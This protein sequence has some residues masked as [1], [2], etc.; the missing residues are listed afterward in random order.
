L[1]KLKGSPK[2][3]ATFST[4]STHFRHWASPGSIGTVRSLAK[5]SIRKYLI[6]HNSWQDNYIN[7]F[8][9]LNASSEITG[10][11]KA[12]RH[13]LSP[14]SVELRLKFTHHLSHATGTQNFHVGGVYAD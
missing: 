13:A 10:F 1:L 14:Y 7:D 5:I 6:K 8:A 4:A 3:S 2:S 9:A 12:H 11:A